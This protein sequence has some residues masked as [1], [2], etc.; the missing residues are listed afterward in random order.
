MVSVTTRVRG[1][2]QPRGGFV[3]PR[4]F[5]VT[6][7]RDDKLLNVDENVH[8]SIIG[9]AVDY[10]TRTE[11]GSHPKVAFEI[12]LLGAKMINNSAYAEE[13]VGNITGLDNQSIINACKLCGFD[14]V[15]RAGAGLYNPDKKIEP[16]TNT[17][18]NI[19]V[20][21]ER[22]KSFITK[23][24]PIVLDGF[25]FVGGYTDV[26]TSGD[27]DFLTDTTLWDFKVSKKGPTSIHTLQLLVYYI[28]GKNSIN[29][30]FQDI[31]NLGIFNPRLNKVHLISLDDIPPEIISQ[32]ENEV[33][34]TPN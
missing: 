10:L 27:G 23:Y 4:E 26:I 17:I 33:V 2:K 8:S 7:L 14:V 15:V 6:D 34:G 12:S 21:V 19:R 5:K 29:D 9:M 13:L 32:V 20:M 3:K 16:D 22:S 25:T 1:Y 30:S 18:S 31:E 11:T 28:M 24:G